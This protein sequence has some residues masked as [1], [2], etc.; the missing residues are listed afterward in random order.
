MAGRVRRAR[1]P[2]AGAGRPAHARIGIALCVVPLALA[3][4]TDTTR[5][6]ADRPTSTDQPTSSAPAPTSTAT[7][8]G[9]EAP[10]TRAGAELLARFPAPA[11]LGPGW[12]YSGPV[13][14]PGEHSVGAELDVNDAVDGSVPHDCLRLN[15]MPLPEAAAQARYT[16]RGTPV[17]ASA[18]GF[19]NPAVTRAFLS[20]LVSNLEDCKAERGD[21]GGDLVGQ[22][23]S[24]GEGIVLSDRLPDDDVERRTD[25]AVLTE[26]SVVLLESPV[27]LGAEP[28]TSGRGVAIA[29]VFRSSAGRSSARR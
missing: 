27:A 16:F 2:A 23:V 5:P 9:S 11:D 24:L 15:P 4:C 17:S 19:D 7:A 10:H 1:W 29:E 18:V 22:V 6:R 13:D 12:A 28:F 21:N 20:L 25:L 14:R 3:G 8:A 26:T